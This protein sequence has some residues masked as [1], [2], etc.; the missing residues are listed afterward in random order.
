MLL[1]F[2]VLPSE[3]SGFRIQYSELP[4][5]RTTQKRKSTRR[6]V[7]RAA[8]CGLGGGWWAQQKLGG[9]RTA[10]Y[11]QKL[12]TAPGQGDANNSYPF[13]SL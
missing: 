12:G 13:K 1:V 3:S 11:P 9:Q 6:R 10:G 4:P 8:D 5:D 2:M 7:A